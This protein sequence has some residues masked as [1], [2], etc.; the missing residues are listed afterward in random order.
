MGS[1]RRLDYDPSPLPDWPMLAS[2]FAVPLPGPIH[3][4]VP[5]MRRVG[6]SFAAGLMLRCGV[7]ILAAA[8]FAW[9]LVTPG[10]AATRLLAAGGVVAAGLWLWAHVRRTNLELARFVEAM[11][12]GDLQQGFAGGSGDSGFA[13]LGRILD[14]AIRRMREE[15]G[16]LTEEA[17]FCFAL[18]EESPTALLTVDTAGRVYLANKSARRLFG[19]RDGVDFHAFSDC[20]E[21]LV[22]ALDPAREPAGREVVVLATKGLPQRV[23]LSTASLS[24]L[25]A[26]L[27]LVAVDPI[28][29]ELAQ[30]EVAAQADLVR[31]L[32][33]EIMNSLTPVTSLARSAA[34]LMERVADDA[35]RDVADAKAAVSTLARRADSLLAFVDSYRQVAAVP[36]VNRRPFAAEPWGEELGRLLA[37]AE[38]GRG[39]IFALHVAEPGLMLDADPDLLAQAL[40]NLM[41]NAAEAARAH[42]ANPWVR[43]SVGENEVWVEDNGP[44]V[45]DGLE[46]DI[47]LPFFTTKAEGSGVGLSV[48]RQIVVAHHGTIRAERTAEGGARLRIQL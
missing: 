9:T 18:V 29:R 24:R 3:R 16:R 44:G 8:V 25:G 10:L 14:E 22:A 26:G 46:A 47:F 43:L 40:I 11:A 23:T 15:R 35:G 2:G 5:D 48:A 34:T 17:R 30:A 13:E 39:V 27:R 4:R 28:Q 12:V 32:T 19:A 36:T 33:H 6:R 38:H 1:E 42:S 21:P 20:G 37:A 45:A 7:I 31:A 41:K